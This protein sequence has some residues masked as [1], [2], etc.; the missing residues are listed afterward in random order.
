[1]VQV[2]VLT[3]LNFTLPPTFDAFKNPNYRFLWTSNFFS[4]VSR[5]MAMT[6]L[7]WLVFQLTDSALLVTLVGFFGMGPMLILR[8]VGGLLADK[9][10]KRKLLV[11]TASANLI[12]ST[13][14]TALLYFGEVKFWHAY[15]VI[16]VSGIGWGLDFPSRRSIVLDILGRARL[17]NAVALDSIGMH[18]SRMIG[19]ALGGMLIT[20][21]GI[22]GGYVVA[23]I[24]YSLSVFFMI[25]VSIPQI[26]LVSRATK[27]TTTSILRNLVEGFG[28]V[29]SNNTLSAL[30]LI[31]ILMNFLLFPYQQL[32]PVIAERVLNVDAGL[33]GLLLA[34]EGL[35]AM[36]GAIFIASR[37]TISYHG[38]IYLYGSLLA[39]VMLS[40]LSISDVYKA[41]L[42]ILFI[43]GLGAACFG[44]M[45]GTIAMLVSREDM[46]GRALGIVTLG[47]GASPLGSLV[48]GAMA[49]I[50]SAPT[51]IGVNSI[52]GLATVGLVGLI[53]NSIRGSMITDESS[54]D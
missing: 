19:P 15:L 7:G 22:E 26:T 13:F 37:R 36:V 2:N 1:M 11:I 27:S 8:T 29:R 46:R 41:S 35:G 20:A 5:W 45:Q 10:D 18:T 4:F 12:A 24:F 23:T 25:I 14:M 54:N 50:T 17:T 33:M 43:L 49:D 47:I 52:I 30:I 31:T 48:I 51:A 28:Y 39:L 34:A 16:V 53:Y 3:L 38:R 44:T 32:I 21:V 40:I 42:F 9:T 6:M